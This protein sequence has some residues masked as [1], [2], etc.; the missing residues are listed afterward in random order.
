MIILSFQGSRFDQFLEDFD[1]KLFRYG[2]FRTF[3]HMMLDF[4][5]FDAVI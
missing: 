5:L 3:L 1:K 2:F 4:Y